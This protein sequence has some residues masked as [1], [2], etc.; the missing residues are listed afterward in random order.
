MFVFVSEILV[1]KRRYLLARLCTLFVFSSL[2]L[3]GSCVEEITIESEEYENLLVVDATITNQD[4]RQEIYLS[5][6]FQ[7]G[8]ETGIPE[9]NAQVKVIGNGI[10]HV[11]EEV[12]PGTYKT[13]ATFKA[14]P[15]VSYQL[16]IQTANGNRYTSSQKKLTTITQIG[17][18][19]ANRI[20]NDNGVDGVAI[21]VDSY[22]PTR[23]SNYYKYS[24]EETYKIIAPFWAPEDAYIIS[25][26]YPNCEVGLKLRPETQRV[27]YTTEFSNSINLATTIA[28]S[29]DRLE[30]H[31]VRFLSNQDFKISHRYSLL[32]HQSV[33][34]EEAHQYLDKIQSFVN[35]GSLF[36]QLQAG[37]VVGNINSISN[38]DEKVIGL[39]EVSSV[40]SSR[41]FFNYED[42]YPNTLLPPYAITC[43]ESSPPLFDIA[44]NYRCGGL[45]NAIENR[46]KVYLEDYLGDPPLTTWGPYL[47]VPRACGD[48]TALGES[49]PPSFWTE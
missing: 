36:S 37:F 46:T 32:V 29:E 10:T 42:L 3:H 9:E 12:A 22:D 16:E 44:H 17:N 49:E 30:G 41:M 8:E 27:C 38:S 7:F 6:T 14:E 5:R 35:E 11:F 15:N 40:T 18:V 39:F 24:F 13:A 28:L 4:I 25:D 45:I 1:F 19:Y 47:M 20:V 26:D 21:L 34:S 48:C 33:I 43:V 2:F 23:T 31:L